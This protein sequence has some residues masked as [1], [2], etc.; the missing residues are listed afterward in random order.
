M[1]WVALW[2]L[3]STTL[4]RAP[5]AACFIISPQMERSS[6]MQFAFITI[7]FCIGHG[8]GDVGPGMR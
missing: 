2:G 8:G 5:V 7:C 3:Y 1:A 4:H 6:D